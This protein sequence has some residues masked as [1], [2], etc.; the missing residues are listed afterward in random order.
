ML[1][2]EDMILARQELQEIYEDDPDDP[3]IDWWDDV[4]DDLFEVI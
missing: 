1:D 2:Y 4:P 3:V